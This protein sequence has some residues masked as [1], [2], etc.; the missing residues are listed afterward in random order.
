MDLMY[1]TEYLSSILSDSSKPEAATRETLKDTLAASAVPR[2]IGAV[3]DVVKGDLGTAKSGHDKIGPCLRYLRDRERRSDLSLHG[4]LVLPGQHKSRVSVQQELEGL[5]REVLEVGDVLDSTNFMLRRLSSP[6]KSATP[7]GLTE[8]KNPVPISAM[9]IDASDHDRA[10]DLEIERHAKDCRHVHKKT[11]EGP[12]NTSMVSMGFSSH[13]W[14]RHMAGTDG[15]LADGPGR[16][17]RID[18]EDPNST[19]KFGLVHDGA[20]LVRQEA[21]AFPA[22][23]LPSSKTTFHAIVSTDRPARVLKEGHYFEVQVK[24]IFASAVHGRPQFEPTALDRPG[25]LHQRPR[26]EGLVLGMTRTPPA[27]IDLTT[28]NAHDVPQSWCVGTSGKFYTNASR[29]PHGRTARPVNTGRVQEVQPW[30]QKKEP[31]ENRAAGPVQVQWP[32]PPSPV[33]KQ[34]VDWSV[35]LDEGATIGMLVTPFGGIVMTVNGKRE[36]MIPD[37][38]VLPDGDLFP[39]VEVYN[40]VRSVQVCA[41]ATPPS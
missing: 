36:L 13:F 31:S 23:V 32:P 40:R 30:H 3:S 9:I 18:G 17:Q 19:Y 39:L 7:R 41:G 6:V 16:F 24:K 25:H 38:G 26:N 35:P 15:S 34:N 20:I 29:L 5:Q 1:R 27:A 8:G 14:R 11:S 37:A 33:E 2:L 12:G 21:Q 22:E 10:R 4:T 28:R